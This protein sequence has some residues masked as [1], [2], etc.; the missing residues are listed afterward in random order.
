[1]RYA[2][3]F[4]E[5]VGIFCIIGV[6]AV[7]LACLF[8]WIQDTINEAIRTYQYKHRFNKPPTAKCYC[9]DC[10]MHGDSDGSNRCDLPGSS[11]YTPDN[12]FCYEAEPRRM[13]R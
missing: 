10:R 6:I 7:F 3:N 4:C 13:K 5:I 2:L 9:K 1:M 8:T 11:R 12:G